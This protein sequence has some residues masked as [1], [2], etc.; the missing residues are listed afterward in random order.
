MDRRYE[1]VTFEGDY[2]GD[3]AILDHATGAIIRAEDHSEFKLTELCKI[4]NDE[5]EERMAYLKI[6]DEYRN[7]R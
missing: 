4:L 7:G 2:V 3:R 6:I 1:C 5:H